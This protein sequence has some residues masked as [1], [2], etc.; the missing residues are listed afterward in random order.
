M[1]WDVHPGSWTRSFYPFQI[2]GPKRHRIRNTDE[3]L[4]DLPLSCSTWRRA[5]AWWGGRARTPRSSPPSRHDCSSWSSPH[6][7]NFSGHIVGSL[8]R[9]TLGRLLLTR[10]APRPFPDSAWDKETVIVNVN[11]CCGSGT[12][13]YTTEWFFTLEVGKIINLILFSR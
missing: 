3:N 13:S 4:T 12:C 9:S 7:Q 2:L 5:C 10:G 8:S 1:V 11:K 6:R